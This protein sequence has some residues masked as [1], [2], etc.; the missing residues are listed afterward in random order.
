MEQFCVILRSFCSLLKHLF[1][2]IYSFQSLFVYF[3]I[4]LFVYF[5]IYLNLDRQS[6]YS[7]KPVGLCGNQ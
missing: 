5:L 7:E 6:Y 1:D 2:A 4:L 3:I